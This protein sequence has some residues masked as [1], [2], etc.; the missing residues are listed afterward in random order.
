MPAQAFDTSR[1]GPPVGYYTY[2]VADDHWSWSDGMYDLRG[3]PPDAESASTE[4]LIRHLH[5]ADMSRAVEVLE[6]AVSDGLPFS[7]LHRIIDTSR[8]VRSVLSVGRG[9]RGDEGKV[10]QLVGFVVDLTEHRRSSSEADTEP[11]PA[12][13][14]EALS[15]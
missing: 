13:L 15:A 11:M 1:A 3:Y 8:Q 2:T 12:R 6:T 4:L 7:C 5:P 14:A 9:L 10:D